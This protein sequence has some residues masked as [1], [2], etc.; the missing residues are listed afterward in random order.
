MP[1][2]TAGCAPSSIAIAALRG[3]TLACPAARE[4]I[5]DGAV[6]RQPLW[7]IRHRFIEEFELKGQGMAGQTG[8]RPP[9]LE[10]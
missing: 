9:I 6:R 1:D 5:E 2:V 8:P 3:G 7:P 10:K 4:H